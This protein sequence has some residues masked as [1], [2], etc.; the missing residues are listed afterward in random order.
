VNTHQIY[1]PLVGAHSR[2]GVGV[3]VRLPHR[4]RHPPLKGVERKR[5]RG[6]SRALPVGLRGHL[7]KRQPPLRQ[8]KHPP[9]VDS[10]NHSCS[11][12]SPLPQRLQSLEERFEILLSLVRGPVTPGVGG[13]GDYSPGKRREQLAVV[14]EVEP[15]ALPPLVRGRKDGRNVLQRPRLP[16]QESAAAGPHRCTDPPL[17]RRQGERLGEEE[18]GPQI[19]MGSDPQIPF[20]HRYEDGG[21]RDGIGGEVVQ[22]HPIVEQD[23]PHEAASRHAE[24]P[25]V[26]GDEAHDVPRRW[27]WSDSARGRN[28]LRSLPVGEGAKQTFAN[29]LLQIARRHRGKW[30]RI[31]RGD[32]GH[33]VSHQQGGRDGGARGRKGVFLS[34]GQSLSGCENLKKEAGSGAKNRRRVLSRVYK[35]QGE[36]VSSAPPGPDAG[37]KRRD[38]K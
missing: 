6:H 22:L 7:P 20:T 4:S 30:P 34:S 38:A 37:F 25:L 19:P 23:R 24:S 27:G 35:D 13:G 3:G 12:E 5:I 33:S 11:G 8:G 14:P 10:G 9:T 1:A 36:T 16:Q 29:Q 26:E 31:A 21:L 17:P 15:P 18:M 2:L 32:D 28:P